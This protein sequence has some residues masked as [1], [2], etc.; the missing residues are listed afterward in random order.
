M[1]LTDNLRTFLDFETDGSTATDRV[2]SNNL[3]TTP[4]LTTTTGGVRWVPG[5]PGNG[6]N[7]D[8]GLRAL[9]SG[10]AISVLIE[11]TITAQFN[12]GD[13]YA[14]MQSSGGVG[15]LYLASYNA[16]LHVGFSDSANV[17]VGA[18]VGTRRTILLTCSSYATF[19]NSTPVVYVN[20]VAQA[21]ITAQF[22]GSDVATSAATIRFLGQSSAA[23][24]VTYHRLAWWDRALSSG[25]AATI[26]NNPGSILVASDT[27][28]PTV[29]AR[30]IDAAGTT[31]TLTFS[32]SV[33]GGTGFTLSGGHTLGT[34]SGSGTS[35]TFSVTPATVSGEAV[36]L[37]YAPGNVAD[38]ASP[39]NALATFSGS[40]VTN[41]S[42]QV[43]SLSPGTATGSTTA[44]S[45]SVTATAASAGTAP[46]AYQWYGSTTSGFTPGAGNLLASQ[47]S[48]NLASFAVSAG[49]TWY[50][51]RRATDSAGSPATAFTPE[52]AY[53]APGSSGGSGLSLA[54]LQNE[55]TARGLT[56]A[57]TTYLNAGVKISTGT[58][59]GQV[60]VSSGIVSVD[61]VKVN[62][63]AASADTA[64]STSISAIKA[65][66]DNLPADPV[67]E[68][69]FATN[70]IAVT[71]DASDVDGNIPSNV[72][73]VAGQTASTDTSLVDDIAASILASPENKIA[74]DADGFVTATNGGSGGGSGGLDAAGVRAAIGLATANLDTQLAA[75]PNRAEFLTQAEAG[76]FVGESTRSMI[77]DGLRYD[78]MLTTIMASTAGVVDI[79]S[80][81]GTAIFMRTDGSTEQFRA[82]YGD[83]LNRSDVVINEDAV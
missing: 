39:P 38:A 14:L 2:G 27:T 6:T 68:S 52:F 7:L 25:E 4:L 64:L 63:Q 37:S 56:S 47:T 28:P 13:P 80:E 35:R 58:G 16:E 76:E 66:T 3:T 1:A 17:D 9:S 41:N 53:N 31:L 23:G 57:L 26:G 54:D 49:T 45:A 36:T 20:G 70:K 73:Q 81:P 67:G 69:W 30:S 46:Y 29:T 65:K 83:G 24:G 82:N 12:F 48:Q 19:G 79:E 32:E 34:A 55:L 40:A 61:V 51:V 62:G 71:L 43:P 42:T 11:M 22:I 72:V 59:S 33:T 8:T 10:Q 60:S 50:F 77:I 21:A 15:P 5:N 74:T 44:I 75:K 78:I 18:A